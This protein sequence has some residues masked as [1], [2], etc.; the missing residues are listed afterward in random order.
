MTAIHERDWHHVINAIRWPDD[1]Q[2]T[3]EQAI[4]IEMTAVAT[5]F[6]RQA[7]KFILHHTVTKPWQNLKAIEQKRWTLTKRLVYWLG[8]GHI[9]V[10]PV[11][12]RQQ[13]ER[14]DDFLARYQTKQRER[15]N[16]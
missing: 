15:G 1:Q 16:S 10:T 12:D 8:D 3:E 11:A 2:L 14:G 4:L 7:A 5:D 13:S 9:R 6:K